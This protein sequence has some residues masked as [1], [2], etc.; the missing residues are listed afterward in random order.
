MLKKIIS[1]PLFSGSFL[2]IGGSM[3]ANVVSYIYHLVVGRLLGPEQYGV[4]ASI[5][6]ILYIVSVVPLSSSIAVV[7]FIADAKDP[8]E[9]AKIYKGLNDF[10]LKIAIILSILM[11]A[12]SW[13][14]ASF[15]HIPNVLPVALLAPIVFF[16]LIT[17]VNQSTSQGLLEFMGVVGPNFMSVFIKLV[18]GVLFIVIGLAVP[19]AMLAILI[20]SILAYLYSFFIVKKSLASYSGH[21]KLNLKPFLK[22]TLPV[23]LQALAFT[24]LFT[25]D[26]ILVKHFLPEFEAGLYA[27]LSTSG[28]IIYFAVTPIAGVM[29]PIVS[30]RHS[31]GEN[32]KKIFLISLLATIGLAIGV[33]LVYYFFPKIAIGILFGK[34][35]LDASGYLILMG[36]FMT[37]YSINYFFVNYF[38]AFGKIKIVILPIAAAILQGVLIFFVWHQNI[39]QVL[40]VSTVLMVMLFIGLSSILGYAQKAS[41]GNSSGV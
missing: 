2:M 4:L 35:Y 24:S 39:G 15:L 18:L 6:S 41:F 29:F 8:K 36:L 23:L 16:S 37:F 31:A 28:K 27:S 13:S 19:G 30:K 9:V 10:V 26:V 5:F 38:L 1:H 14:I 7:K 11:F 12:A 33:D 40:T 17:L 3:A 25:V 32:Y 22:Y 34:K 20:G 21:A